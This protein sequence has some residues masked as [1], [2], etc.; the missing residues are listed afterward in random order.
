[1]INIFF[2]IGVLFTSTRSTDLFDSFE[3]FEGIELDALMDIVD[4]ENTEVVQV[5]LVADFSDNLKTTEIS[6]PPISTTVA[7]SDEYPWKNDNWCYEYD[8][9]RFQLDASKVAITMA[10]Q[11]DL[12]LRKLIINTLEYV[13]RR[14]V[15]AGQP[16]LRLDQVANLANATMIPDHL[17]APVRR[18]NIV[19][20]HPF[21][22]SKESVAKLF[23]DILYQ[24]PNML[25]FH[26]AVL[27]ARVMVGLGLL[28]KKNAI[29]R[30]THVRI[31]NELLRKIF[32]NEDSIRVGFER[33]IEAA[34]KLLE[35]LRRR[36][37]LED[38]VTDKFGKV[39]EVIREAIE[40]YSVSSTLAFPTSTELRSAC[41]ESAR[42]VMFNRLVV[43][44]KL[45][46]LPSQLKKELKQ[47]NWNFLT[48]WIEALDH[49]YDGQ[50][51][52]IERVEKRIGICENARDIA[53]TMIDNLALDSA[54][55]LASLDFDN[56][57]KH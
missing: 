20:E 29:N 5:A 32:N 54:D 9:A 38:H 15:V 39:R 48:A 50:K 1:M 33:R 17:M 12:F 47:K 11:H 13:N 56:E 42:S 16:H 34:E 37:E 14:C 7:P 55:A 44:D 22:H 51:A 53:R 3:V 57:T 23:R 27:L 19:L 8:E 2:R 24:E 40:K 46:K 6:P 21:G 49:L 52:A 43:N 30:E 18:M 28:R 41:L 4:P 10:D 35:G 26:K 36:R 25:N 31:K 45:R